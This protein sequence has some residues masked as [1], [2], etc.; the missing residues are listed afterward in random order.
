MAAIES[1]LRSSGL[2]PRTVGRNDFSAKAPLKRVTE[3][4]SECHGTVVLAYERTRSIE[5]INRPGSP[6]QVVARDVRLPTVWNQIEAAMSYGAGL[7]L[8]VIVEEGLRD[9][10]LLESKYD[11]YIQWVTIDEMAPGTNELRAVLSDWVKAVAEHDHESQTATSAPGTK[12]ATQITL[13]EFLGNSNRPTAVGSLD[14]ICGDAHCCGR[15]R[16]QSGGLELAQ[17][18]RA[19]TWRNGALHCGRCGRCVTTQADSVGA[20]SSGSLVTYSN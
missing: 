13:K 19:I 11:W 10:G 16:L 4:L 1:A 12:D 20:S 3:V 8:L 17:S 6:T 14:R 15:D 9:E 7:P 5:T 2:A 18:I